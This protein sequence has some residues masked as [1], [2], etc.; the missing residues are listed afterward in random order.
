MPQQ[1]DPRQGVGP[2]SQGLV[3]GNLSPYSAKEGPAL[4]KQALPV[5]YASS[6]P[7]KEGSSPRESHHTTVD[8]APGWETGTRGH[9]T[10]RCRAESGLGRRYSEV[11]TAQQGIATLHHKALGLG[12]AIRDMDPTGGQDSSGEPRQSRQLSEHRGTDAGTVCEC[13]TPTVPTP[14]DHLPPAKS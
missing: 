13:N 3:Q 10:D 7:E 11:H 4:P 12:S 9:C 14:V 8:S 1:G 6:A 2:P 5:C